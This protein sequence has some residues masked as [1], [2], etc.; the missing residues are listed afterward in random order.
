MLLDIITL[1]FQQNHFSTRMKISI[2]HTQ[3]KIWKTAVDDLPIFKFKMLMVGF[4]EFF[5]QFWLMPKTNK[6]KCLVHTTLYANS[7][8]CVKSKLNQNSKE[9]DTDVGKNW[10]GVYMKMW[11]EKPKMRQTES[12]FN[13]DFCMML[14]DPNG[15]F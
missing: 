3:Y 14:N 2:L 4:L 5:S 1:L 10:V 9:L 8:K 6:N 7:N 13:L 15:S 12:F 11:N